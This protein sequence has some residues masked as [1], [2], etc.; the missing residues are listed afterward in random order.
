M[1][2]PNITRIVT[3]LNHRFDGLRYEFY[4]RRHIGSNPLRRWS[5]HAGSEP[6]RG[7]YGNAV[8]IFDPEDNH[9]SA[10]LDEVHA[11]LQQNRSVLRIRTILWRVKNHHNHIHCDVWPKMADE[12]W[13]R[14]PPKGPVLTIN[15][16]GTQADTYDEEDEMPQFTEEEAEQLKNLV[17]ALNHQDSTGYGFAKWG[18]DLIRREDKTPLHD[19]EGLELPID[20]RISE[21]P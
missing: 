15:D 4:N 5:Q 20:V 7:W 17:L 3:A 12:F 9:N 21:I 18:V 11:Y 14:P 1:P 10:L 13:R 19:P 16:V 2:T 8:D 6:A